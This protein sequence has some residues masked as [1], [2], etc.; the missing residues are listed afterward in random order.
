MTVSSWPVDRAK[1]S[2]VTAVSG[3]AQSWTTVPRPCPAAAVRLFCLP[4]AGAGAAGFRG[5]AADFGDSVEVVP[6]TLPG[7]ERRMAETPL[8]SIASIV[9]GLVPALQHRLDRPYVFF[10]HSLGALVAYEAA[11]RL[12][13]AGTPPAGLVVSASRAPHRPVPGQ[14]YHRLPREQFLA[15]LR[16]MQPEANDALW[17]DELVE[18]LLPMLLADFTAD[19]RY[20]APPDRALGCPVTVLGGT[21]DPMVPP[22]ELAGWAA[23][24]TG[25]VTTHLVAGGHLFVLTA[26]ERVRRLVRAAL[27]TP[28][29]TRE[30]RHP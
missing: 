4:W 22:A 7:R 8:D 2:T 20:V 18:L 14:Q 12:T 10:G 23:H 30:E 5:W 1:E 21:D 11:R 24:T 28:A 9:D 17:H 15:A 13:A 26:V 29:D 27:P 19:E 3:S 16:R 25:P 6:V